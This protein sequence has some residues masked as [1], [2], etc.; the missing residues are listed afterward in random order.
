MT[1]RRATR[2]HAARVAAVATVIVMACYAVAVVGL[3]ALVVRRLTDEVDARL[4]AVLASTRSAS[5]DQSTQSTQGSALRRTTGVLPPITPETGVDDAPSFVWRVGAN[6]SVTPLTVGSPVLPRRSWATGPSTLRLGAT[7]FRFDA[8]PGGSG[9]LVVGQ[10]IAEVQRVQAALWLPVLAFGV[11]LA[12]AV[13]VGSLV[14]GLRASAPLEEI[15]RRQAEFTADASHELRTPLSVIEAEVELALSG[16]QDPDEYVGVLRRVAGEGRRLRRIV[17]DLLWLARADRAPSASPAGG[18]TDLALVVAACTERFEGVAGT[19]GVTLAFHP[20]PGLRAPV[21]ADADLLDRL[22]GVLVDNACKFAG[23]DGRV[24]VRVRVAGN[25]VG[26]QVDDTGPG[27]APEQRPFIFDRFHR[28][29]D[30]AEGTG[31]GLAVAD[32]V[33]RATRGTW[34]VGDAP[35]GGAR[36]EVWWPRAAPGAGESRPSTTD[37]QVGTDRGRPAA[38]DPALDVTRTG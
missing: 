1:S 23:K 4:T 36:M 14:V 30:S 31:L 15:R 34:V 12:A 25:R 6:G 3:D 9:W 29:D 2:G 26:L 5:S 19:R 37:G 33:V 32:S 8:A 21:H 7:L 16:P 24:D 27:I 22:T 35:T 11:V 13:F 38:A 17:D 28:V 18:P 10:S 20:E